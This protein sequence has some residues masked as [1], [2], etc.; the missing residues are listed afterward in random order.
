MN[1]KHPGTDASFEW[2]RRAHRS[3]RSPEALRRRA[4]ELGH[5]VRKGSARKQPRNRRWLAQGSWLALAATMAAGVWLALARS[6]PDGAVPG[7]AAVTPAAEPVRSSEPAAVT[8]AAEPV[9]PSEP[10]R[11]CP[12]PLPVS[13]WAPGSVDRGAQL[14]G[15]EAQTLATQT[16]CGPLSRRYLLRAVP[17]QHALTPVLIVLHDGGQ[18]PE[19]GQILTRWWFDDLSQRAPAVLV[20]ANGGPVVGASPTSGVYDGV[21]QTD[22]AAHPAVDDVAYLQALV[23]DLR[24]KHGLARGD[25][26]LAGQGSGAQM[27]LVAALQRGAPYAGV[28]AFLPSRAPLPG[29]LAAP[30]AVGST[31]SLSSVFVALPRVEGENP[32]QLAFEWASAMGAAPGAVHVTREKPG[33][34][35]IDTTVGG[36][37]LRIVTLPPGV[38]P[39]PGPGGA[40][41][42]A[43]AASAKRPSFFDGP[44][45]AWDFFQRAK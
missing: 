41:P 27:A 39:F 31:W 24:E 40:D 1:A 26:Y 43:R 36:L 2:L 45:K 11:P 23:R 42:L 5:G 21:W 38:D 4:L 10:A 35:R 30:L 19:Q 8:P 32:S 29:E 25:I 9:P 13:L 17:Q 20:Y 6:A 7:P 3:E 44:G 14:M 16:R 12:M 33:V 37:P 18:S 22:A 28:A 34:R 15:L